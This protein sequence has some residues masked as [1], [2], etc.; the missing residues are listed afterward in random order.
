MKNTVRSITGIAGAAAGGLALSAAGGSYAVMRMMLGGKRQTYEEALAWQRE[1]HDLS[2]FDDSKTVRY[3]IEGYNGYIL[4]GMYCPCPE[5]SDRYMILTHGYSD[6]LYGSLKYTGMYLSLGFNCI[7]YDLRGHGENRPHIC[8]YTVLE[9]K[10]LLAVIRD[11]R[12]RYGDGIQ[13]GLHGESLG[14]STTAAVL[15]LKPDVSFAVCDCGFANIADIIR[16]SVTFRKLPEFLAEGAFLMCRLLHG[17]SVSDMRPVDRLRENHIP[18]LFIHGADDLFIPPRHSLLMHSETA[19]YSEYHT[20]PGAKHAQS[21][22][23]DPAGYKKLV[24]EFLKTCKTG[25]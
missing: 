8:T 12:I 20:V 15:G 24:E 17:Y 7:L 2:W 19:G 23:T 9:S 14:A 11:T 13:I 1:H 4:H 3:E 10:D 22:E 18:I 6:N 25:A 16:G 5:P 21:M